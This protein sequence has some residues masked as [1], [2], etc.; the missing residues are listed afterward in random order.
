MVGRN[1]KG[2]APQSRLRSQIQIASRGLISAANRAQSSSGKARNMEDTGPAEVTLA[3]T[4]AKAQNDL[5]ILIRIGLGHG[6]TPGAIISDVI[7]P[8]LEDAVVSEVAW[9]ALRQVINCAAEPSA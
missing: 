4:I 2:V 7:E 5:A 6:S 9:G 3:Q 8:I 1:N